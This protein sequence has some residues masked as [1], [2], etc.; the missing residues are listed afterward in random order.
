MCDATPQP[1]TLVPPTDRQFWLERRR[2][3]LQELALIERTLGMERSYPSKV[4]RE[5]DGYDRRTQERER[6]DP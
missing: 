5:R 2:V 1:T 3:L 6:R 4:E